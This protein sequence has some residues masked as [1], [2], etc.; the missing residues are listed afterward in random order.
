[1]GVDFD[2]CALSNMLY[3]I[4]QYDLPRNQHDTDSLTYLRSVV[5]S[6]RYVSEPFRCAPH[7]AR[8]SLIIYHLARLMA[9][10]TITELE[11]I[12]PRLIADAR[13]LISQ[14]SQTAWSK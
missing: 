9:A 2:A 7:Y 6:G 10:F 12:R 13:Q 8:T 5:E 4:Y 1:M 14:R 11:P 3:C